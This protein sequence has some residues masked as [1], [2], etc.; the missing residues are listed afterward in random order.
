MQN[1]ENGLFPI[2]LNDLFILNTEQKG[3]KRREIKEWMK[4]VREG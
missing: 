3:K 4:R 2:Y 1:I